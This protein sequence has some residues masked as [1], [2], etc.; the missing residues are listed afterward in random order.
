MPQRIWLHH[1][2]NADYTRPKANFKPTVNLKNVALPSPRGTTTQEN[3]KVKGLLYLWQI[4]RMHKLQT[5]LTTATKH[6]NFGKEKVA[7][8]RAIVGGSK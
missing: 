2:W 5:G 4:W 6:S 8:N 3:L 7:P 1:Q